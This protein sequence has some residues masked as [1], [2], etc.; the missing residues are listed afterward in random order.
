MLDDTSLFYCPKV[1]LTS[2]SRSGMGSACISMGVAALILC[3]GLGAVG[4]GGRVWVWSRC[5]GKRVLILGTE[6]SN[7][8]RRGWNPRPE[9]EESGPRWGQGWGLEGRMVGGRGQDGGGARTFGKLHAQ[10]LQLQVL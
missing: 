8:E 5:P 7:L 2:W 3:K 9:G 10:I 6:I 1:V 4:T